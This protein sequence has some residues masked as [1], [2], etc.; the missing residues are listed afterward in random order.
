MMRDDDLNLD[1]YPV[2]TE[3]TTT[4]KIPTTHV[5]STDESR[6]KESPVN[7]TLLQICSTD[8]EESKGIIINECSTEDDE[9]ESEGIITDKCSTEEDKS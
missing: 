9:S 2:R 5:C 7:K 1:N 8:D 3:M 4:K 6:L